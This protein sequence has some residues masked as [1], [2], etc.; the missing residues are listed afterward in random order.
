M[1]DFKNPSMIKI[2]ELLTGRSLWA[3]L[4]YIFTLLVSKKI[5]VKMGCTLPP[6]E[7]PHKSALKNI[8]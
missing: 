6:K 4:K 5:I 2:L 1:A 7:T 3:L 8:M